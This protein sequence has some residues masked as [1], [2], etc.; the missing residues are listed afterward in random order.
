M[1]LTYS[2]GSAKHGIVSVRWTWTS[3]AAGAATATTARISGELIKAVT[4][5][6][7]AAPTANYDITVKDSDAVNVLTACSDDLVDRHTSNTEE[8]YFFVKDVATAEQSV[9]P[10]VDSALT[11]AVANAGAAKTGTLV[12]YFRV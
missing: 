10:V 4:D 6:G 12:L 7:A 2:E 3:S 1:A 9:H 5:P 11:L 8:V